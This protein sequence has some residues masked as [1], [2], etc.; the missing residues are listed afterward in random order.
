METERLMD[1]ETKI[2]ANDKNS[3][4]WRREFGQV[5]IDSADMFANNRVTPGTYKILID[6]AA[7]KG[8]RLHEK[9]IQR[10]VQSALRKEIYRTA[11]LLEIT[12]S[13]VPAIA[14]K[15]TADAPKKSVPAMVI[16][17]PPAMVSVFG[18]RRGKMKW[19]IRIPIDENRPCSVS[20][21]RLSRLRS[22]KL[23]TTRRVLDIALSFSWG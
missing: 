4:T 3:W 5:I 9:E 1:I 12:D 21:C 7:A 19:P 6:A 23:K 20:F 16:V 22:S 14:P 13:P 18:N 8:L 10:R 11:A 15:L 2:D 17:V